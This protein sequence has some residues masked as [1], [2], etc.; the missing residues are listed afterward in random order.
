MKRIMVVAI[1]SVICA[2][3]SYVAWAQQDS[4]GPGRRDNRMMGQGGV[5]SRGMGQDGNAPGMGG[6]M[7]G[8]GGMMAGR[9]GMMAGRMAMMRMCDTHR[10]L[11]E[12]M[13]RRALVSTSDGGVIAMIGSRLMKYDKDLNLVKEADM[14]LDYASI[15]QQMQRL[16]ENCPGCR[17]MSQ[18]QIREDREDP[19]P[20]Q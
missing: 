1:L 19:S 18:S 7:M 5:P 12:S 4:N 20:E 3:G 17:R 15:E 6:G 2:A 8:R 10:M 11:A 9:R 14:K 13:G 16:M